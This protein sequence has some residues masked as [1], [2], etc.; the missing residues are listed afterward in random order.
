MDF[1]DTADI[2]MG[3]REGAASLGRQVH[4]EAGLRALE[5]APLIQALIEGEID[6]AHAALSDFVQDAEAAGDKV[7]REE[8]TGGRAGLGK[9]RRDGRVRISGDGGRNWR[10]RSGGLAGLVV[11]LLHGDFSLESGRSQDS[12]SARNG[13]RGCP[14]D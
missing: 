1:E 8:R 7:A 9:G 11:A 3:Y 5:G 4:A 13:R 10:G 12:C 14:R 2:G 6:D